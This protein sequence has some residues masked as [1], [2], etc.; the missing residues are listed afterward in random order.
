M[1]YRLDSMRDSRQMLCLV[2]GLFG[3]LVTILKSLKVSLYAREFL[4]RHST[5]RRTAGGVRRGEG[6]RYWRKVGYIFRS[7]ED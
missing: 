2:I 4:S 3:S 7:V 6:G 1:V 5:R